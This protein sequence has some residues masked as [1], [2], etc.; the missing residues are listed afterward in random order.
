[1]AFPTTGRS[2]LRAGAGLLLLLTDPARRLAVEYCDASDPAS[3]SKSPPRV[4]LID[5]EADVRARQRLDPLALRESEPLVSEAVALS[6][7]W[8]ADGKR[9]AI[10]LFRAV[11]DGATARRDLQMEQLSSVNLGDLH[12]SLGL[13]EEALGFYRRT[14]RPEAD[15]AAR[16]DARIGM[17]RSLVRL[18]DV[19]AGREQAEAALAE[20]RAVRDRRREAGALVALGIALYDSRDLDAA[21]S[22]L[23]RVLA[24]LEGLGEDALIA[25]ARLYLGCA[26]ADRSREWLAIAE[27]EEAAR[28]AR[29]RGARGLEAQALVSLGHVLSKIGEKQKA[30]DS[31]Y[32]AAPLVREAG[33][34]FGTISLYGGMGYL[35]LELGDSEGAEEFLGEV[36]RLSKGSGSSTAETAARI[37]LARVAASRGEPG[38]AL[39]HLLPALKLLERRVDRRM[40]ASVLGDIAQ[41]RA[42]KGEI[43]EALDT[44]SRAL[45]VARSHG[46]EREEAELLNGVGVLELRMGRT[47]EAS[48]RFGRALDLSR[49]TNSPF[50]E[51]LALFHM[52]RVER[53][54]GRIEEALALAV[55][56]LDRVE[57]IRGNVGSRRLRVS[58]LASVYQMHTLHVELL[59]DLERMRPASGS[60]ERAFIAA[61]QA[62]ARTL[63]ETLAETDDAGFAAADPALRD[64]RTRIE[65]AIH[66]GAAGR[67]RRCDADTSRGS[68]QELPRL[69]A[70]F[71][72]VESVLESRHSAEAP[73]PR[74][75][76]GLRELQRDLLDERTALLAYFLGERESYVWAVDRNEVSVHFLP[77]R[78]R[79]ESDAR[80]VYTLLAG[81]G[82]KE[83]ESEKDRYQRL[84]RIDADYWKA[85][86][87]LSD[88]LLGDAIRGLDVDRFVI[89]AD[90]A[91]NRIPFSALPRP[92]TE[93]DEQPRPMI[94]RYE[95][96]RLPSATIWKALAA[97]RRPPRAALKKLAVLADPVLDGEDPRLSPRA[98]PVAAAP[99]SAA[100]NLPDPIA[101]LP[102]LLS[103]REEARRILALVPQE[104][105]FEALGFE[106]N[107]GLARSDRLAEYE[108]VHFATHG[109]LNAEHPELSGIV[110]SLFDRQGNAARGFLRLHDIYDL[111]LPVRLVVLSACST[112]LGAEFRGEGMVGLV[113][114]FLASGAQGVVASYWDVEDEATAELMSRFYEH[115]FLA[116]QSPS[117]SL[118]LAQRSMWSES[119]WQ[120]PELWGAFEFQGLGE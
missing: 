83:G 22:L 88:S 67:P 47:T 37:H 72:R 51:S 15:P 73:A 97:R 13:D 50:S 9:K 32:R 96:V 20:S 84:L 63:L 74:E 61:E 66:S 99:P 113:G 69:L 94:T 79:L 4:L 10:L 45:A 58:Y 76:V 95:I 115:L 17:S 117:K 25:E 59:M 82:R 106:A 2:L 87:K 44:F 93:V 102:R 70:E 1:M 107:L 77:P 38:E 103:T 109:L 7:S 49:R 39:S 60:F 110:L 31:Y 56:A 116:G 46:L 41:A 40:E 100:R 104:E 18:E 80:R 33:D 36:V 89:V 28:I 86:A 112:G 108:V 92:G 26:H 5:E 64:Y 42:E 14:L 65:E 27:L 101:N 120:S 90:G 24:L 19:A 71:D 48:A 54:E 23:E 68:A 119:R 8:R 6:R 62:R 21:V 30:L 53:E 98:T 78:E 29:M 43:A 52:A 11:L 12:R 111:D 35:L 57:E 118:Q 91:L 105:R 114:G 75:L 81:R 85:A 55:E 16:V 3:L 34:P